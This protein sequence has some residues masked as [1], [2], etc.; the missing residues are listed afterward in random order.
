MY[1][2]V[3]QEWKITDRLAAVECPTLVLVGEFD[4]MTVECSMAIV[5]AIPQCRPLVV[6]PRASHVKLLDEP[7]A[8]VEQVTLFLKSLA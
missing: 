4:T 1:V 7:H 2:N 5:S 8:C 3:P 6:I